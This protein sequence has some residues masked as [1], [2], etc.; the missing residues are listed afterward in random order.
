MK[1]KYEYLLHT[2]GGFWNDH[3]EMAHKE[4]NTPYKWFSSKEERETEINR[5]RKLEKE[6][7][8]FLLSN[9]KFNDSCI[10]MSLTEGYLTRHKHIIQSLIKMPNGELITIENNLG[11]GFW[12]DEEL[13]IVGDG[14]DYFKEW[15]YEGSC[16]L[17]DDH[18]R[19]FSTIILRKD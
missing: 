11:Y 2:W 13:G 19:I 18:E 5:L 10:A 6:R 8:Q 1:A 15:K 12:S 17:P 9:G 7:A 4:P 3:N 14:S 16:N